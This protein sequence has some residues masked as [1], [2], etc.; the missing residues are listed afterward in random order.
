MSGSRPTCLPV[1]LYVEGLRALQQSLEIGSIFLATDDE[2][3]VEE[4]KGALAP[5]VD[6]RPRP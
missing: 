3:V 4:M 6:D 5:M 1:K 2:G